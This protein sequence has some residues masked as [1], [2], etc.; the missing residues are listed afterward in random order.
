MREMYFSPWN[1]GIVGVGNEE[2]AFTVLHYR[3]AQ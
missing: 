3:R 2:V 1:G